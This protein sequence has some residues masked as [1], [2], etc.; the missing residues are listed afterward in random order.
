[1][2]Y[3]E[4]SG[5]PT[6][7]GVIYNNLTHGSFPNESE[8]ET[9]EVGDLITWIVPGAFKNCYNLKNVT[10]PASV[11]TIDNSAFWNYSH[12]LLS[13]SVDSENANYKSVN[14]LLLSKDG[15]T[16]LRGVNGNVT[17]PNGVTTIEKLAFEHC[18]NLTS[19]S[20]PN[21]VTSIGIGAFQECQPFTEITIPNSVINIGDGAFFNCSLT[22]FNVGTSNTVYKSENGLLLSKDGK[23]LIQ[24]VN[25]NVTIPN[26]VTE[27]ETEAFEYLNLTGITIPNGVSYIK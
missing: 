9:I 18:Y 27:I 2:T 10:I 22:E 4:S 5:L 11:R 3:T 24:G 25:G 26:S 15:K 12:N 16:L 13:I 20:I 21:S 1:M 6:W 19:V 8:A 7:E 14:G 17:I 23:T